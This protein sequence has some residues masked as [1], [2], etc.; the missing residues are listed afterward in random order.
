M[1]RKVD[2]ENWVRKAHFEFFRA[3]E[4]PYYGV[5]V[6]IDCSAAYRFAKR[7]GHSVFLYC[8]YQSLSAA[9]RSE[10]FKLRIE[11]EQGD[12]F[13]YERSTPVRPSREATAPSGMVISSTT[14]TWLTF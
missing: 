8:L 10:P 3:F 14:K 1:K 7:N 12:V 11:Q 9:Q 2:M 13:V 5:C 6:N 4:E